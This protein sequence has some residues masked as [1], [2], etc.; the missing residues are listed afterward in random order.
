RRLTS[1]MRAEE[2]RCF[3][4]IDFTGEGRRFDVEI[5]RVAGHDRVRL[6][7]QIVPTLEGLDWTPAATDDAYHTYDLRYDPGAQSAELWVD[8]VRR[9]TGY[10]GH[11][12]FQQDGDLLFG[13]SVFQ[14][15]RGV[16]SFQDVRFEINP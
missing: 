1:V 13:V 12:Q 6:Q 2:G 10:R 15:A 8:G 3:A 16:A 5:D 7:T 4:V 11:S 9:L 14:S